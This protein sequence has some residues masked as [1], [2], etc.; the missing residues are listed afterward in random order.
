VVDRLARRRTHI[1][2]RRTRLCYFD[3]I[4]ST[5]PVCGKDKDGFGLHFLRDFTADLL[6]LVEGGCPVLY[7]VFGYSSLNWAG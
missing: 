4:F 1:L 2:Y 3:N 5:L 6:P 7:V